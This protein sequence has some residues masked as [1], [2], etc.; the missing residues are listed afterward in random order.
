MEQRL[1]ELTATDYSRL[2]WLYLNVGNDERALDIARLGVE[3]EP[4]N[5]FCLRLVQKLGLLVAAP[6]DRVGSSDQVG[7][8]P[9]DQVDDVEEAAPG[10]LTAKPAA[11]RVGPWPRG[12][13][14]F[15]CSIL[16]GGS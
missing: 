13:R 7:L 5:Y 2:S 10:A 15:P 1:G 4:D 8:E 12:S 16:I 6:A 9:V 3:R 14:M 11:L